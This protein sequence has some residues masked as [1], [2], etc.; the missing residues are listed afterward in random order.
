[1][2]KTTDAKASHVSPVPYRAPEDA[3]MFIEDSFRHPIILPGMKAP[4]PNKPAK[5]IDAPN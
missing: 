4:L 1:L 3:R 2:R 5:S